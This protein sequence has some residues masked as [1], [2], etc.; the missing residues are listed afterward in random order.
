MKWET[1]RAHGDDW[2]LCF[3]SVKWHRRFVFED[4]FSFHSVRRQIG[5]IDYTTD[6]RTLV[7]SV[8]HAIYFRFLINLRV[9][10]KTEIVLKREG[11]KLCF[12]FRELRRRLA[13]AA[14]CVCYA[15]SEYLLFQIQ[16]VYLS[17]IEGRNGSLD[18]QWR[19]RTEQIYIQSDSAKIALNNN[20]RIGL[21][22]V[23]P[24]T[25]VM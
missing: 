2:N 1:R 6:H 11:D 10:I 15:R 5:R 13:S 14:A 23:P 12:N 4:K 16:F 17:T 3:S 18:Q 22:S 20:S 21:F 8:G 9:K 24:C 7:P 25:D 19:F